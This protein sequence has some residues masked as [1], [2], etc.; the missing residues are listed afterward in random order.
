MHELRRLIPAR[1][2]H[3]FALSLLVG[4]VA[5]A[6]EPAVTKVWKVAELGAAGMPVVERLGSPATED[7]AVRFDGKGDGL[8]VSENPLAGASHFTIQI[9]FRP[10]EGGLSA[11]RFFH[12]QDERTNR[13]MIETRLDGKGGWW[14]DTFLG[15]SGGGKPLIDPA[16]V[17]PTN[18]WY[19]AAVRY[20]AAAGR[21]SIALPAGQVTPQLAGK[22][23]FYRAAAP[24]LD[25]EYPLA[26]G[27]DG[28]QTLDATALAAGPWTLHVAW[29]VAGLEYYLEQKIVVP[30]K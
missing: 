29:Q 11:Q 28:T 7:Q 1:V 15:N 26:P 19:W 9:L 24:D 13:V 5:L 4:S 23:G 10:A 6:G 8:F 12:L 16:K 2:R 3:G 20:D 17:H 22:I 25:R 30:A 14:L 27:P 21:I 18:Q